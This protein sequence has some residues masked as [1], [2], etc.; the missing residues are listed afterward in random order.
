MLKLIVEYLKQ[1]D[2]LELRIGLASRIC[3]DATRDNIS[4][5]LLSRVKKIFR[6]KK[7]L[8]LKAFVAVKTKFVSAPELLGQLSS[9]TLQEL[10][11]EFA[12]FFRSSNLLLG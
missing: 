7:K 11:R 3:S 6:L 1:K 10:T 8:F 4:L 2:S 5:L 9:L 12:L